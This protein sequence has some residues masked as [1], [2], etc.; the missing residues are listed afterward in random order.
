MYYLYLI[1]NEKTEETYIGITNDIKRRVAE[2]NFGISRSTHRKDG[3][4]LLIYFEAYRLKEDAVIRERK[5]KQYGR[6]RQESLKRCINSL[7]K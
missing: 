6:T 3:N 4:W 2:H 7:I 1:Q 5:M